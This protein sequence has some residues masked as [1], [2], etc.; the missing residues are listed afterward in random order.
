MIYL[1]L[2]LLNPLIRPGHRRL[3]CRVR[4][5]PVRPQPHRELRQCQLSA[6]LSSLRGHLPPAYR[7]PNSHHDI[8]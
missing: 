7:L 3:A 4:A 6:P 5:L 1:L 2:L 8:C